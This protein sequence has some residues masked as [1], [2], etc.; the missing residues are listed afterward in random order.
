MLYNIIIVFFF[1][2]HITVYVNIIYNRER[3]REREREYICILYVQSKI[4]FNKIM[5]FDQT[6]KLC[7]I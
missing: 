4:E 6:T 2:I 1:Y 5:F 7:L 3:E